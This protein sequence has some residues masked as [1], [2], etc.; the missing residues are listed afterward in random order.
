MWTF[1]ACVGAP[2]LTTKPTKHAKALRT[3]DP[4]SIF[5]DFVC[6]VVNE[7]AAGLSTKSLKKPGSRL[8]PG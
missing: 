6:F 7:T 5:V 1:A 2:D 4:R 3:L 8:S